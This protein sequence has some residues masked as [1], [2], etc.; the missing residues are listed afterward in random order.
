M[1][2]AIK[3]YYRY[4]REF[5]IVFPYSVF[6]L[7]VIHGE[8]KTVKKPFGRKLM[9]RDPLCMVRRDREMS[10]EKL[11][12]TLWRRCRTAVLREGIPTYVVRWQRSASSAPT[13]PRSLEE[14]RTRLRAYHSHTYLLAP[15]T[16][17]ARTSTA[18]ER[19]M[20]PTA[21]M[22]TARRHLLRQP[23]F[24][25]DARRRVGTVRAFTL[26]N[27]GTGL[28]AAEYAAVRKRTISGIRR[29]LDAWERSGLD[30]LI[31][32]LR[33]HYGGT[34][35]PLLSAFSRYLMGVPLFA[36]SAT[37][38]ADG[39]ALTRSR[40]KVWLTPVTSENAEGGVTLQDLAYPRR[41]GNRLRD[42]PRRGV[43]VLLS[44]TTVS[45]G[46]IAAAMFASK[47]G[48][49]TFGAPTG[50]A[51][52]VND[53]VPIGHG[54]S[55]VLTKQLM[56]LSNGRVLDDE[57]LQPDVITAFPERAARAW[58]EKNA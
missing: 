8:G 38:P 45:S 4:E 29:Q 20:A 12:A 3:I 18:L 5:D 9:T 33:K 19:R 47:A 36:W 23:E 58:L 15:A 54:Y 55:L 7:C 43:A 11:A 16:T 44:S 35:W 1:K 17:S 32:D 57:R 51:A 42:P 25:Y 40:A 24:A 27:G 22:K 50:G 48:V 34:F 6:H 53:S 41:T 46:E 2:S 21:Q 49:R 28:T 39:E 10:E 14:L 56:V 31:I 30:G 52:S 13:P 37:L 26:N